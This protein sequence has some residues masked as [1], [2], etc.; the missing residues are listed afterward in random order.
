MCNDY[1]LLADTTT[2]FADFSET[3]EIRVS[4]GKPNLV[5]SVIESAVFF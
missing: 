2:L 1:R 4:E 5:A 3:I